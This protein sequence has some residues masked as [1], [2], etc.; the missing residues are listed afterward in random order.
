MIRNRANQV[1]G[2]QMVV[3]ASNVAF[4]GQATVYITGDGGVQATGLTGTGLATHEG[5]G[6]HTYVADVTET[7]YTT[8]AFTFTGTDARPETI[9]LI[10]DDPDED[11]TSLTLSE[12]GGYYDP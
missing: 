1:V 10:T 5:N 3:A 9:I 6:F 12:G 7:D 2:A 8:V 4:T 11:S